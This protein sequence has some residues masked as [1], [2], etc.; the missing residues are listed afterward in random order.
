MAQSDPRQP[1]TGRMTARFSLESIS[2][3]IGRITKSKTD[4]ERYNH[5]LS[6]GAINAIVFL[7][8]MPKSVEKEENK[9]QMAEMHAA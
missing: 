7:M 6:N 1:R 4:P 3:N 9:L 8:V 2:T 5:G